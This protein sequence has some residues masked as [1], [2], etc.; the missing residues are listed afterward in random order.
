MVVRFHRI[1]KDWVYSCSLSGEFGIK[2]GNTDDSGLSAAADDHFDTF[3]PDQPTTG[4]NKTPSD[5]YE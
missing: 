4:Q 3:T 5:T 2:S 1:M